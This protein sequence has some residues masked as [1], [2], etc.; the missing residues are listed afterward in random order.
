MNCS[1]IEKQLPAYLEGDLSSVEMEELRDHLASCENCRKA[2]EDLN[3]TGRLVHDLEEVSPPPRLKS[4]IMARVREEADG[5]RGILRKFFFPLYIKIPVQAFAVVVISVFAFYLY[6]QDVPQMRIKGIPL[7]PVP[8]FETAREPASPPS[9]QIP[10]KQSVSPKRDVRGDQEMPPV[11]TGRNE[12]G[13]S[14][15]SAV[16]EEGTPETG[17]TAADEVTTENAPASAA[18]APL[19]MSQVLGGEAKGAFSSAVKQKN[20]ETRPPAALPRE[21][22]GVCEPEEDLCRYEAKT[23]DGERIV[24]KETRMPG[25]EMTLEWIL[26]VQDAGA[27][28]AELEDYAGKIE[29]RYAGTVVRDGKHV[30]TTDIR[31]S[32][33]GAFRE[34]LHTL[35]QV[36]VDKEPEVSRDIQWVHIQVILVPSAHSKP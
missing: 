15:S 35:G 16:P 30:F 20:G 24:A 9:R 33:V 28:V 11:S 6:R 1:D 29:S 22:N 10:Q 32:S 27:A 4:Q 5:K 3:K 13:A 19:A 2:L 8:I 31:P 21:K 26:S 36:S 23:E 18:P 12:E 34:K 25:A 17:N 7:P 14:L